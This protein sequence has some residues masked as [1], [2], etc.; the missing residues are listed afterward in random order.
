M[1][2][3]IYIDFVYTNIAPIA[4]IIMIASIMGVSPQDYC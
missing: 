2:M 4:K 3:V 1:G